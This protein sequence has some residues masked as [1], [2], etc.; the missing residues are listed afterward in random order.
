VAFVA[1][2]SARDGFQVPLQQETKAMSRCFRIRVLFGTVIALATTF[3]CV[4]ASAADARIAPS[5]WQAPINIGRDAIGAEV[6]INA[7]GGA[8]V[9]WS[10]RNADM[11]LQVWAKYRAPRAAWDAP[12]L[13]G[14]S[15]PR[16]N[17]LRRIAMNPQGDAVVVWEEQTRGGRESV[18]AKRFNRVSGWEE[19]IRISSDAGPAGN[20]QVAISADGRA[21]TLWQQQVFETS[22]QSQ[23]GLWTRRFIPGQGWGDAE[24]IPIDSTEAVFQ[25]QLAMSDTGEV[26]VAWMRVNAENDMLTM[27]ARTIRYRPTE[28][29]GGISELGSAEISALQML[30]TMGNDENNQIS[31]AAGPAGDA[32]VAWVRGR[33]LWAARCDAS[34]DWGAPALLRAGGSNR[35]PWLAVNAK[36]AAVAIWFEEE[37]NTVWVS[38]SRAGR[39]WDPPKALAKHFLNRAA[40]GPRISA[41]RAGEALAVWIGSE[42]SGDGI[43]AARFTPAG[44]A[45]APQPVHIDVD[46]T[47]MTPTVAINDLGQ[48]VVAWLSLEPDQGT[49][50]LWISTFD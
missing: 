50:M 16:R 12:I 32:V 22:A 2:K 6:A 34:G 47:P 13:L 36:G 30:A 45:R 40:Y 11:T 25:P 19:S 14:E 28:G 15:A 43:I 38:R 29:W 31:L 18:L 9:V 20:P 35:M 26:L 8:M 39:Q 37:Q 7:E 49:N 41:N 17:V 1:L 24:Q 23:Q 27:R 5:A 4:A 48:A 44:V 46:G 3:A 10:Q 42:D 33:E 21:I